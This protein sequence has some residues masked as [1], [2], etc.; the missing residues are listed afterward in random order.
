MTTV[1]LTDHLFV[2]PAYVAA[3]EVEPNATKVSVT[4]HNGSTYLVP[5]DYGKGVYATAERL[6]KL[7]NGESA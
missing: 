6:N 2:N 3:I 4:M 7:V 1:R 5:P